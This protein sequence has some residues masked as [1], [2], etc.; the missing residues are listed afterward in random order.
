[1]VFEECSSV[2]C[3]QDFGGASRWFGHAHIYILATFRGHIHGVLVLGAAC[4]IDLVAVV[5]ALPS[6]F[7]Y[8]GSGH[9]SQCNLLQEK[10]PNRGQHGHLA[11][12][13]ALEISHPEIPGRMV[14]RATLS[15]SCLIMAKA[16]RTTRHV[17]PRTLTSPTASTT[18]LTRRTRW[19]M[20][21]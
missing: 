15:S 17:D 7:W 16:D 3:H 21:D 10:D 20:C 2:V 11:V 8:Y 18:P 13:N 1:M 9:N 12:Y 19:H 6:S 4:V 14:L 5:F